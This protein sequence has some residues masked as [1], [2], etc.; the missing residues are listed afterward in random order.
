MYQQGAQATHALMIEPAE[1]LNENG[2]D[3]DV[4]IAVQGNAIRATL[5][6]GSVYDLTGGGSPSITRRPVNSVTLTEFAADW[7]VLWDDNAAR[8]IPELEFYQGF[9][10]LSGSEYP[11]DNI[12]VWRSNL[13]LIDAP[14]DEVTHISLDGLTSLGSFDIGDPELEFNASY[15][16]GDDRFIY[17]W[18]S[19]YGRGKRLTESYSLQP[20]GGFDTF[21]I[22]SAADTP[23][24]L[25]IRYDS[26][27]VGE[28]SI[29]INGID[30][31][32]VRLVENSEV[33]S[34]AIVPVPASVSTSDQ[35]E[36]EVGYE[37]ART[38]ELAILRYWSFVA[39]DSLVGRGPA[40]VIAPD[41]DP[42]LISDSFTDLDFTQSGLHFPDT[43]KSVSSWKTDVG[44]WKIAGGRMRESLGLDRDSRLIIEAPNAR[45][46]S[47][48]IHWQDDSVG[49]I[50]GY[51]NPQNWA[52]YYFFPDIQG[53]QEVRF[54][55]M[56]D[57]IFTP[58]TSALISN[59][60]PG[61]DIELSVQIASDRTVTGLL[62]G[63]PVLTAQL[64]DEE[65]NGDFIGLMSR[66]SGNTFDNFEAHMLR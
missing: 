64:A 44:D 8:T 56:D 21:T 10:E 55:V 28:L 6:H 20:T 18:T 26:T 23:M 36:V 49:I 43:A 2:A 12:A 61:S 32:T 27:R 57:G 17:E 15:V 19:S 66:G 63:N 47:T 41:S 29:R 46:I 45:E 16:G 52:M 14:P 37:S 11:L 39:N 1:W 31:G 58:T 40:V 3:D 22:P 51:E 54:G 9:T 59:R 62:D 30:L 48:D 25:V 4:V 33:D 24:L 50:I 60:Q 34:L 35:M 7:I 53:F 5:D 38:G 42:V 13:E 65:A